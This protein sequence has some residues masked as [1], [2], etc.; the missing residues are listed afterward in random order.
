M[1]GKI[2][3]IKKCPRC[4]HSLSVNDESEYV[5]CLECTYYE[6]ATKSDRETATIK[7]RVR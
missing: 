1:A 4:G 2:E 7:A 5:V 6:T 3:E